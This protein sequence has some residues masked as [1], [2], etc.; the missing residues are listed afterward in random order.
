VSYPAKKKKKKLLFLREKGGE[1]IR[2]VA[3]IQRER[4]KQQGKRSREVTSTSKSAVL[5][6]GRGVWEKEAL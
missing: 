5:S 6:G 1:G 2:L 4:E 3:G